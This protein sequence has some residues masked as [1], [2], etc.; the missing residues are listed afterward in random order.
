MFARPSYCR[1]AGERLC[2]PSR[3]KISH[4]GRNLQK[5]MATVPERV[6]THCIYLVGVPLASFADFSSRSL[7][8]AFFLP[9]LSPLARGTR[10]WVPPFCARIVTPSTRPPPPPLPFA[11]C[12]VTMPSHSWALLPVLLLLSLLLPVAAE[13]RM[14][15]QRTGGASCYVECRIRGKLHSPLLAP[16]PSLIHL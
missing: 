1:I 9:L 7:R 15:K 11:R 3:K 8:S 14:E 16:S 13:W 10:R 6:T 5:K 4:R 12:G 2:P